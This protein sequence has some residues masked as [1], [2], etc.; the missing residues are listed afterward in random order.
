MATDLQEP[1]PPVVAI[2]GRPNVGKSA[3]LN[4]LARERISI[5]DP[6]SGVT[7]DRVTALVEHDDRL[8]EVWDT[9]GLGST[10]DLAVEV[11]AQIDIAIRRADLIL[12]V[13]D[14][15][16]GLQP[17][18]LHVAQRLR[19]E[20]RPILLVVNKVD[21]ARHEQNVGEFYRL[22][23][24]DPVLVS[25]LH[26]HGRSELLDRVLAETPVR[27][28]QTPPPELRIAAVGRQNVGKST[29]IN[30]L[31]NEERVIVSEMPGTTRDSIDVHFELDGRSFVA[32]D[33]AGV[34]RRTR[35]KDSVEFYSFTRTDAAIRRADVVLFMIDVTMEITRMDMRIGHRVEE[36]GKPCVI[37]VNKWDLSTGFEP[38]DYT[39]YLNDHLPMLH[40]APVSFICARDGLH[41]RETIALA[42]ALHRQAQ[43]QVATSR[44]NNLLA[45]AQ[46]VRRPA[47][48]KN[49]AP[50]ILYGTQV[51]TCPPTFLLFASHPE[52]ITKQYTRFLAGFLRERLD[53]HEVPL[54]ILYRSRRKDDG[55]DSADLDKPRRRRQPKRRQ[56]RGGRR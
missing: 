10:D 5:V 44:L 27:S 1:A 39:A 43:T 51:G 37:V 4:C 23:L 3:L 48:R 41:V 50:R 32:I 17:M 11:E 30:T 22:G 55:G 25:A 16:E 20:G 12:M 34:K 40:Y 31:A 19:R 53:C 28:L 33:T 56:R 35:L 24:G 29:L 46:K 26:R 18:D 9:G 8:I 38:K 54:R 52:L 49:Q 2:V 36:L 47:V 13:V 7:R 21:D 6:A 42:Q 15:L 14:V 45:E